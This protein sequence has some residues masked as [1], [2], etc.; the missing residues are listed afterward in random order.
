M[1]VGAR[2]ISTDLNMMIDKTVV[3]K[4]INNKTYTGTLSS[5]ETSPFLIALSNAKDENNNVYYKVI[6]NG[7]F[8]Q[9]ILIKTAPI[10]DPKEFAEILTR[11][12][13]LRS[14]DVRVYEEAGIVT[15]LDKIKVS[16]SGVEGSGPLAQ[17]IYDIFNDYISKK[18]KSM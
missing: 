10:F 2:K 6:L 11:T 4:M 3:V 7:S 17:R 15:V 12:L 9:E 18:K 13:G 16:E 5:Y 8:I 14:G 1:S